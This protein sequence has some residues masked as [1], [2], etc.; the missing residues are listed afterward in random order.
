MMVTI[1]GCQSTNCLNSPRKIHDDRLRLAKDCSKSF[2]CYTRLWTT[3]QSPSNWATQK[4]SGRSPFRFYWLFVAG[5]SLRLESWI[6]LKT[7]QHDP[8][9]NQSAVGC[10]FPL[11]RKCLQLLSWFPSSH[12]CSLTFTAIR[13]T[14]YSSILKITSY[15]SSWINIIRCRD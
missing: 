15:T 10:G 6:H 7:G 9:N 4:Y 1:T 13:Q 11:L 5:I 3:K 12:S 2:L 8:L 14:P